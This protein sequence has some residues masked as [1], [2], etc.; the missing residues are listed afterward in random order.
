ML[1]S[2]CLEITTDVYKRQK[3]R[4]LIVLSQ[5]L[6]DKKSPT[7]L[8]RATQRIDCLLYTSTVAQQVIVL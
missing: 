8:L 5:N 1:P 3:Y 6:K 7:E 2:N 4:E